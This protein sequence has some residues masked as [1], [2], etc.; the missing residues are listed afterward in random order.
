[1]KHM[2]KASLK[3]CLITELTL[4]RAFYLHTK[5]SVYRVRVIVNFM[6]LFI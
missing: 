6:F 5:F 2:K 1:M 3:S 4:F